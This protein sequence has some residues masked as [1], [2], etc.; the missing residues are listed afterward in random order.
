MK[1]V[2][3]LLVAAGCASTG[4]RLDSVAPDLAAPG[5][6]V[7]LTGSGFCGTSGDC[8]T[9][10][11]QVELGTNP[12]YYQAAVMSWDQTGGQ[13]IVPDMP[14]GETDLVIDVD[15]QSSNALSFIVAGGD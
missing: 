8:A 2:A 7:Q 12:P 13:I 11:A 6:L 9:V 14:T 15:D 3:A 1:V 5:D 10:A 4:P